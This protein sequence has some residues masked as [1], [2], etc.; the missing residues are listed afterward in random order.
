MPRQYKLDGNTVRN[1]PSINYLSKDQKRWKI[2]EIKMNIY[3]LN[4]RGI[5]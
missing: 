2:K 3:N 1:K 4:Q 5:H